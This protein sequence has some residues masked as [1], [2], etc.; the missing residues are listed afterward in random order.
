MTLFPSCTAGL[1][2]SFNAFFKDNCLS[3]LNTYLAQ[4]PRCA[5]QHLD[6]EKS[7]VTEDALCT[8]LAIIPYSQISFLNLNFLPLKDRFF[9][10]F[11]EM[12]LAHSTDA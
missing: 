7:G 6:L 10:A 4:F 3:L 5:L 2:L 9:E 1:G 11:S 8:L 12:L